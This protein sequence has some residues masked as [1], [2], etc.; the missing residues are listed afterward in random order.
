MQPGITWWKH[1][2]VGLLAPNV[3]K[4]F[5]EVYD[6]EHPGHVTLY[7]SNGKDR[8][9]IR[10]VPLEPLAH[11]N[12]VLS[13]WGYDAPFIDRRSDRSIPLP[14]SRAEQR[15]AENR[16]LY[17]ARDWK[18]GIQQPDGTYKFEV[19]SPAEQ[20]RVFQDA[21]WSLPEFNQFWSEVKDIRWDGQCPWTFAA[22]VARQL[23][24]R[25]QPAPDSPGAQEITEAARLLGV[26][27]LPP[28]AATLDQL[29][30]GLE[31]GEITPNAVTDE[32]LARR[33][34][35]EV[36]LAQEDTNPIRQSP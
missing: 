17:K 30:D 29:R 1:Q 12:E 22:S 31:R 10:D 27:L 21:Y 5:I 6:D 26:V 36:Q 7:A 8:T 3:D 2:T 25:V 20:L 34:M 4:R 9:P 18:Q 16:W 15:R 11:F 28:V 32:L 13:V 24:L 14:P 23:D 33:G 35:R 19:R